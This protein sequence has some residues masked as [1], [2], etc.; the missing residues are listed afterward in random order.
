MG[1]PLMKLIKSYGRT[2]FYALGMMG[3][4]LRGCKLLE[5]VGWESPSDSI[6][7]CVPA[8]PESS[9]FFKVPHS[10]LELINFLYEK[11]GLICEITRSSPLISKGCGLF[12]MM[13]PS[14]I[15]HK[16]C[17]M[18]VLSLLAHFQIQFSQTV[19]LP[20]KGTQFLYSNLILILIGAWRLK[21][22]HPK[23]F[24]KPD[25]VVGTLQ[26]LANQS[27]KLNT[28]RLLHSMIESQA[29]T[30]RLYKEM[31]PQFCQ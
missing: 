17:W 25:F 12:H 14:R 21:S 16:V 27:F 10:T 28:R 19:S 4:S 13:N 8:N 26:L 23:V 24:L 20:S 22:K 1:C 7:L 30:P 9:N 6:N 5:S 11:L 29:F 15:Y 31:A 18:N 3:K 2:C